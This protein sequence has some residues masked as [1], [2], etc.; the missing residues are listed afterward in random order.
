VNVEIRSIKVVLNYLRRLGLL[1]NLTKD[2][3]SD[4]LK[5][6]KTPRP[7]PVILRN[8]QLHALLKAARA[9]DAETFKATRE[10]HAGRSEAGSTLRYEPITPLLT[11]AILSGM[12]FGELHGLDWSE[13]NLEE[14][15]ISLGTRTKT[16]NARDIDLE[17]SPALQ[18]VLESLAPEG[19]RKGPVWTMTA[20]QVRAAQRRLEKY[21]APK[22]WTWQVLRRTCG[23]YLTNAPGIFGGASAYRSAKQLG[24]SVAIAE[25]FYLGVVKV[26]AEAK[27]LEDAMGIGNAWRI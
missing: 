14:K 9:H 1:P 10:E 16:K 11:V 6:L 19:E 13:V 18:R 21:G 26:P 22:E 8:K 25:K 2:D 24:H 12:R 17:V 7:A 23:T 5:I 20:L 27:T 15:R 4:G 3:I